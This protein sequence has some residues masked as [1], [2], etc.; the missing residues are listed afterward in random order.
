[1]AERQAILWV[2][3]NLY[4]MTALAAPLYLEGYELV[5][6]TTL[7]EAKQII[8]S[9]P[10]LDLALIDMHLPVGSDGSPLDGKD[11]AYSRGGLDGG[12]VLGRFILDHRPDLPFIGLSVSRDREHREWFEKNGS[13]YITKPILPSELRE[14]ITPHLRAS[15][16]VSNEIKRDD[17][18]EQ[19]DSPKAAL[20]E[21]AQRLEVELRQLELEYQLARQGLSKTMAA[22]VVASLGV[23]GMTFMGFYASMWGKRD[24]LSGQ[25]IVVIIMVVALALVAFSSLVFGRAAKLRARIAEKEKELEIVLGERVR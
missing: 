24:F 3:D 2:D 4:E 18:V 17:G 20:P 22:T 23:L 21:K 25:N 15:H 9:Y 10:R 11:V 7:A 1:M 5:T 19:L 12:L 14:V 16:L 6:A 8:S 13:G